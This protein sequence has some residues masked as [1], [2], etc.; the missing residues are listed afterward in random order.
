MRNFIIPFAA[1]V[2]VRLIEPTDAQPALKDAFVHSNPVELQFS[3]AMFPNAR[4][5]FVASK[6]AKG[7]SDG[8][9]AAARE[10]WDGHSRRHARLV[11]E[12]ISES[13]PRTA[14]MTAFERIVED[15]LKPEAILRE[16]REGDH[17]WGLWLAFLR[18]HETLVP[19]LLADLMNP[20]NFPEVILALG[21]SGDPRSLQPLLQLLDS[22]DDRIPG[23][24]ANALG[25]M[26]FP[27]AEQKLIEALSRDNGWLKVHACSSLGKVG[28][29][30]ALPALE[31]IASD[32]TYAGALSIRSA[33]ASAIES[34]TKRNPE[35]ATPPDGGKPAN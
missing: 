19:D 20:T 16:L 8:R 13:A 27:E 10:L 2:S 17:L 6:L 33:A 21:K 3:C 24:A 23:D 26:A 4:E 25:Y 34:I 7:S 15:S 11:M 1:I 12:F 31:R 30:R 32:Q 28:S 29:R 9:T 14:S 18:P 5:E 22:P 35:H